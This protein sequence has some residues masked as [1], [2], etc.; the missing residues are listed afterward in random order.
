MTF[1]EAG[2]CSNTAHKKK[3]KSFFFFYLK[4]NWG[5]PGSEQSI[6]KMSFQRCSDDFEVKCFDASWKLQN[7]LVLRGSTHK[8]AFTEEF[9]A[10][11]IFL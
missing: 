7:E 10:F 2:G 11:R 3:G 6:E 4:K 9:N 8:A 1:C 5:K